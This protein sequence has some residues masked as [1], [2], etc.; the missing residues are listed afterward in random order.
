MKILKKD[1]LIILLLFISFL[2]SFI[3]VEGGPGQFRFLMQSSFLM[4][5]TFLALYTSNFRINM[6]RLGKISLF[7]LFFFTIL[8]ILI[9]NAGR[10]YTMIVSII[11]SSITASVIH[12]NEKFKKNFL[13]A[14]QSLIILSI[15]LLVLQLLIF[16]TTGN[17]IKFHEIFYPFSQGRIGV[18]KLFDD[19]YRFGGLYIEPGTY[20]NWL[21][22]FLIIYIILSRKI[23]SPLVLI[24]SL[25][26]ILSFS[27]WG[28]IFGTYLF[29]ISIMLKIKKASLKY[30]FLI[31][32]SFFSFAFYSI[33]QFEDN[34]AVK[35]AIYKLD[36]DSGNTSTSA[37]VDFYKKYQSDLTKLLFIGEGYTPSIYK[38]IDSPQDTGFIINLSV[39]FGI[40]FTFIIF[41]IFFISLVKCCGWI[42][43]FAFLPILTSKIYFSD[44]VFWLLFF[45]VIYSGFTNYKNVNLNNKN[46]I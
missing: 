37:K 33:T 19:L 25:S 44:P 13:T 42:M 9:S 24:G 22:L 45:L 28:M 29:I 41:L 30:K 27:V 38:G 46:I 39:I 3:H 35:F 4:I 34:S 11:F 2:Y 18:D 8:S 12:Y 36:V 20:S 23:F 1:N 26:L 10:E 5:I 40:F 15:G 14:L 21:Y 6:N 17:I 16:K 31:L 32:L 7:L 43:L